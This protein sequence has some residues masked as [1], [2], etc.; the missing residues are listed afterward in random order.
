MMKFKKILL[1]SSSCV[2]LLAAQDISAATLSFDYSA[3]DGSERFLSGKSFSFSDIHLYTHSSIFSESSPQSS[4]TKLASVCF[5]TDAGECSGAGAGRD[6]PSSSGPGPIEPDGPERCRL[7]GYTDEVCQ[8]GFKPGLDCPYDPDWHTG[9]VKACPVENTETCT[10][11]DEQG[12]GE[13][14]DGLY[15]SCCRL[16]TDFPYDEIKDGY[17]AKESCTDCDGKTHYKLQCDVGIPGSSGGTYVD[18][19]ENDGVSS[20]G[21]CTDP[22]T[23]EPYYKECK[24][25]LNY[26]W[27]DATKECVC[28][29]SFK[30]SC[31]GTGYDKGEGES[32]DNKY[33]KCSCA[34]D[35][36]WS[37]SGGCVKCDTSFQYTCSG[38]N[39]TGGSGNGC[40]GKY[41]SCTCADGYTWN[42]GECVYSTANCKVGDIYYS[43]NTCS[44]GD[45]ILGVVMWTDG[46]GNGWVLSK[47]PLKELTSGGRYEFIGN[48]WED[49]Y[50]DAS[51]IEVGG[52]G[53]STDVTDRD[54]YAT[55]PNTQRLVA[56]G[57]QIFPAAFEAY[58]YVP[59]GTPEGRKWCLP[60][61]DLAN[62]L[63]DAVVS[64]TVKKSMKKISLE[65]SGTMW[66]STEYS[67]EQAW[68]LDGLFGNIN[69]GRMKTSDSNTPYRWRVP[70]SGSLWA[71]L[72]FG[73]DCNEPKAKSCAIGDLLYSDGTCYLV[74]VKGKTLLGI[75]FYT[76][77]KGN[78]WAIAPEPVPANN[79]A[80]ATKNV[81]I[82]ELENWNWNGKQIGSC[83]QTDIITAY[84]DSSV[85]PAAWAAKNYRPTGTPSGLRWCLPSMNILNNFINYDDS[86]W[87]SSPRQYRS[88]QSVIAQV[89]AGIRL[90]GGIPLGRVVDN[91]FS[92]YGGYKYDYDL[93]ENIWSSDETGAD[94]AVTTSIS[95]GIGYY[96]NSSWRLEAVSDDWSYNKDGK[97]TNVDQIHTVRPVICFG[98]DTSA[99]ALPKGE[100]GGSQVVADDN[101]YYCNGKVV[102]VK[103]SGM[104]FYIAL[105][106]QGEKYWSEAS[107]TANTYTFCD[108]VKGRLPKVS[109]LKNLYQNLTAVNKL[110][111]ENGGQELSRDWYW[112]SEYY[113]DNYDT[114]YRMVNLSDGSEGDANNL[115]YAYT[116]PV[117][118]L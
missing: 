18:C 8:E 4:Q 86:E 51:D 88:E 46:Q 111:K 10:A 23:G 60:S 77:D 6:E 17:E 117:L 79:I 75:V 92:D 25:P 101:F 110:L 52:F 2:S 74:P 3:Y 80:W 13:A 113:A 112:T 73:K 21:V 85:F 57:E 47:G 61:Y 66:T 50:Y 97:R 65:S 58:A 29:T 106:N 15:A 40:G 95:Y 78:G 30:Y 102:G 53:Y 59:E 34:K 84:G 12:V 32:C 68:Y 91:N 115:Y 116:L 16:C 44:N 89:N 76:D 72:C 26:E 48:R 103:A 82:P 87:N 105:K 33:Q 14:C 7:E 118:S 98:P 1:V 94:Q 64:D 96:A 35:Y 93:R 83:E 24:C 107:N 9:C 54:I 62:E 108:T 11:P 39:M 22:E 27:S 5:I 99:C 38:E 45:T 42:N 114:S 20:S 55:C 49:F 37:E 90:V 67:Y 109:E 36:Q 69:P 19:G 81:D 56:L 70:G 28:A 43:N 31:S 100:S 41:Q 63:T 71:V 104:N